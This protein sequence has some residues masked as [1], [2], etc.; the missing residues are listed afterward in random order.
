MG[1][2]HFCITFP[3]PLTESPAANKLLQHVHQA[4]GST[5]FLRYQSLYKPPPQEPPLQSVPART[6]KVALSPSHQHTGPLPCCGRIHRSIGNRNRNQVDQGKAQTNRNGRKSFGARLSVAPMMMI[7]NIMVI[8]TSVTNAE[9]M[10]YPPGE[11]APYPLDAKQ[12]T[13]Q[14]LPCHWQSQT[15]LPLPPA[16]PVLAPQYKAAAD[17]PESGRPPK[18]PPIPPD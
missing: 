13:H 11:C 17:W 9:I 18:A 14:I 6:T 5:P 2:F 12:Q 10:L 8:T 7:R 4:A 15:A 16:P 1:L 3:Q